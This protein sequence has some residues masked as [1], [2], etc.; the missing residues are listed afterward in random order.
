MKYLG[1]PEGN[2]SI[3]PLKSNQQFEATLWLRCGVE[4]FSLVV[5]PA[6]VLA[7]ES[8]DDTTQHVL[9]IVYRYR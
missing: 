1:L 2:I 3:K 5:A 8:G 6:D 7:P 9:G 4:I